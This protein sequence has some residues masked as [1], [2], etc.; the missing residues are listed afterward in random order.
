VPGTLPLPGHFRGTL[1]PDLPFLRGLKSIL[2]GRLIHDLT[3]SGQ[4]K[5]EVHATRGANRAPGTTHACKRFFPKE[6]D[7]SAGHKACFLFHGSPFKSECS[8][9]LRKQRS[10]FVNRGRPGKHISKLRQSR[11]GDAPPAHAN[12]AV[13]ALTLNPKKAN[14]AGWTRLRAIS[15]RLE[16]HRRSEAAV[17]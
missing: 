8:D 1:G 15:P 17:P 7:S 9:L 16:Y 5:F 12:P 10:R 4:R 14:P 2:R 13:S 3:S 6:I 11:G